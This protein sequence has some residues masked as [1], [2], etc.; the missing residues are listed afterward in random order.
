MLSALY[1]S[2]GCEEIETV[3][4]AFQMLLKS[5]N[6]VGWGYVMTLASKDILVGEE[7]YA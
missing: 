4:W 7:L 3:I 6:N 1:S 2:I 5:W